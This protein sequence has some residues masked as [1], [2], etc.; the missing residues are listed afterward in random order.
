MRFINKMKAAIATAI[1]LTATPAYGL[2]YTETVFC[3]QPV[4]QYYEF[5]DTAMI[6]LGYDAIRS[7][8]AV[9]GLRCMTLNDIVFPVRVK[10]TEGINEN[11]LLIVDTEIG[12]L[13]FSGQY[14]WANKVR[15]GALL[16]V[17]YNMYNKE[18][19]VIYGEHANG[20]VFKETKKSDA[21]SRVIEDYYDSDK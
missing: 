4:L 19:D 6:P 10:A 18:F 5:P 20:A 17:A 1:I 15:A 16:V 3:G 13:A 11:G 7:L 2:D 12:K 8:L 14:R 21:F 9:T